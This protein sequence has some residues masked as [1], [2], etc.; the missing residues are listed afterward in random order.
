VNILA[1]NA[2]SSSLKFRLFRIDALRPLSESEDVLTGGS[3]QRIGT[4]EATLTF[5]VGCDARPDERAVPAETVGQAVSEILGRIGELAAVRP[6]ATIDAVGHRIVHGG[7]KFTGPTLVHDETLT[8]IRA[9]TELAPLHNPAGVAGVEA[10]R[11]ALPGA[12]NVAVFDTAF[13]HDLPAVA[14]T[15]ALPRD[16]SEP[17]GLRRYGFHGISYSYVSDRLRLCQAQGGLPRRLVICHLGNGA[18]V[19]ALSEG[20][21]VDTSMGFTPLEGLVMGTRSGD[22]DPG[23]LLHLLRAGHLTVK[24]LDDALNHRSGLLG[25]S[26]LSGDVRDLEKAAEEGN[27]G[28][29]LALGCFAYRVRKYVGAYAAVLGGL[30]ALVFTGGIGEHS[31]PTRARICDSLA[32]LG[33]SLDSARNEAPDASEPANI[34]SG[35]VAVWVVPTDE[36]R[37][38]ARDTYALLS[39]RFTDATKSAE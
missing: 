12:Q 34:G 9:L 30:D 14:A 20:R 37:Q 27:P 16:L 38:I 29:V 22:V 5:S 6:G 23:L 1:L 2:G 3:V 35:T 11:S 31:A 10:V 32:F 28:A 33:V 18:S 4:P 7:S 39:G 25:L 24:Q 21:S 15:Y 17:L 8:Q 19:C 36:E 26:G 13:H